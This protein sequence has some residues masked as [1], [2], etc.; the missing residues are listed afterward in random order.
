MC[1]AADIA[2]SILI[3]DD[4][5]ILRERLAQA[6]RERGFEVGEAGDGEAA[7][8]L[9][10]REPPEF[11]VVDLKMP[12]MGGLEAVRRILEIDPATQ[13]L[14]LTGYGSIATA[15]EAVRLGAIHYLTKP[16]DPDDILDAFAR[17]GG[18][19]P[20]RGTPLMVPS[21]AQV[22]WEH[23]QRVMAES[24]GNISKA[25][26]LLGIHRRS[27]QRKLARPPGERRT[28]TPLP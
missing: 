24:G 28:G 7:V 14:V 18:P 27:L 22:E 13:V 4:D 9:C 23:I 20:P 16:A 10:E 26:R 25:A 2:R 3:V 8:A 19:T 12:G 1:S 11:A 6:F 5:R 17:T 21:L 15:L